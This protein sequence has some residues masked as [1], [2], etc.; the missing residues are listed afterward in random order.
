MDKALVINIQRFSLHDGD[1]VRTSVFFKGCGLHCTWCHNPESQSYKK[2]V[3]VYH[4]RCKQCGYCVKNCS[5]DAISFDKDKLII[6]RN[7]CI[8]CGECV[9]NCAYN[10]L[11][12]AGDYYTVDELV[13]EIKKDMIMYDESGGGVT[14]SGGEVM[15]QDIDFLL[16]LC[17]RLE[18]IGID[19]NVDTCGFAPGENYDKIAPYVSK[20][21]YDIKTMDEKVHKEHIGEGLER[22][23]SNLEKINSLGA[24]INIRIPVIGGVNNTQEDME[25]IIKYLQDKNINVDAINLLPYHKT[26]SSKYDRLNRDYKGKDLTVPKQDD[27][28]RIKDIFIRSGFTNVKI[29]G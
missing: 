19:I 27:M 15:S 13:E 4:E 8:A 14:L 6:D 10:A 17:K 11:E 22:V 28:E 23:L 25:A 16:E 3:M 2:Q 18:R 12:M 21:L 9:E 20:F 24:K 1:G 29:G 7:K 5:E 26:G